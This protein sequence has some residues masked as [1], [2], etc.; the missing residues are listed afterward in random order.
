MKYKLVAQYNEKKGKG[1]FRLCKKQK[2]DIH[3]E[4][5]TSF[6]FLKNKRS[7]KKNNKLLHTSLLKNLTSEK[8]S[9]AHLKF[10]REGTRASYRPNQ[11]LVIVKGRGLK[12]I[13][14]VAFLKSKMLVLVLTNLVFRVTSKSISIQIGHASMLLKKKRL[15]FIFSR[16]F[17]INLYR[18]RLVNLL[19]CFNFFLSTLLGQYL[20]DVIRNTRLKKHFKNLNIAIGQIK[21]IFS[22]H[23]NAVTGLKL[24][25][26]GKLGGKMRKS[27]YKYRI[28]SIPAFSFKYLFSFS[29]T[30]VHT[31]YGVFSIK[32]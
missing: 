7:K 2:K 8:K 29:T 22:K 1:F 3:Q 31:K 32:I 26:M 13:R 12:L 25:I 14:I 6:I 30:Q 19:F 20:Q 24:S 11:R 23:S 9:S 10:L 17:L 27:K 16:L 15:P 28:G 5:H 21:S 18:H 4:I